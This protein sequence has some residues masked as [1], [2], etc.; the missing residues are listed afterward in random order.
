M[1]SN[2]KSLLLNTR[3]GVNS[4]RKTLAPIQPE[5]IRNKELIAKM[6]S[7]TPDVP[8]DRETRYSTSN[9]RA[10]TFNNAKDSSTTTL[11]AP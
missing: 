7:G 8:I 1:Q 5:T 4:A 2:S 11:L 9:S 3:A 10:S 6:D